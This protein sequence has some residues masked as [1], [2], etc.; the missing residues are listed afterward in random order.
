ME[1]IELQIDEN[2]QETVFHD[3]HNLV[4]FYSSVKL[5]LK[6]QRLYETKCMKLKYF[7][8]QM[9]SVFASTYICE[10]ILFLY[11]DFIR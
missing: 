1:I 8:K 2:H 6:K 5:K 3:G 11:F 4:K 9:L 7:A 10:Q